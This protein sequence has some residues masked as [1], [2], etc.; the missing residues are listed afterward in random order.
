MNPLILLGVIWAV[1][2]YFKAKEKYGVVEFENVLRDEMAKLNAPKDFTDGLIAAIKKGLDGKEAKI[3]RDEFI[4]AFL[5]VFDD[6]KT[7]AG[8]EFGKFMKTAKSELD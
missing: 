8:D 6:Y 1:F 2:A 4:A 7:K 3:T 5:A